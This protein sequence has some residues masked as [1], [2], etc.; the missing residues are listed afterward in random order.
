MAHEI[1]DETKAALANWGRFC[2]SDGMARLGYPRVQPMFR[3]M[4]T[5]RRESE[6]IRPPAIDDEAAAIVET[7][8]RRVCTDPVERCGLWMFWVERLETWADIAEAITEATGER[9]TRITGREATHRGEARVDASLASWRGF[10]EKK[11]S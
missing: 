1:R 5:G 10:N 8:I 3:E 9:V 6:D 4:T 11:A 2:R 7:I